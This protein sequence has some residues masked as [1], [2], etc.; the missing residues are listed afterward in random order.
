MKQYGSAVYDKLADC[1]DV[2]GIT[3]ADNKEKALAFISWIEETKKQLNIPAGI[4]V[5]LD[6]DIPQI[7]AWAKKEANPLYPVP[8]IW[9]EKDFRILLRTIS[10]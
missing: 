10:Q 8:V 1:A 7:I 4:D 3:G 6:K 5:I 2:C 9:G